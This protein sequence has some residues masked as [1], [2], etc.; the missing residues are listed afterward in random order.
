MI[1]DSK[2]KTS[3]LLFVC[4]KRLKNGRK[5][6]LRNAASCIRNLNND[7]SVLLRCMERNGFIRLFLTL[8][9]KYLFPFYSVNIPGRNTGSICL[10]K[11][12]E[13]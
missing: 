10:K 9:I 8:Y 2:A 13:I 7:V 4:N 6:F 11:A 12:G 3:A 1:T 5:L